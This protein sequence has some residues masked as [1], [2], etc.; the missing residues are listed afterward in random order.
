MD[1]SFDEILVPER[2]KRPSGSPGTSINKRRKRQDDVWRQSASSEPGTQV[3]DDFKPATLRRD[4]DTQRSL[5]C[6]YHKRDPRLHHRT[7][8]RLLS[9]ENMR[10]VKFHIERVHMKPPWCGCCRS[11]DICEPT[12]NKLLSVNLNRAPFSKNS[13]TEKWAL[14]YELLFGND[15]LIPSPYED[16]IMTKE[17]E[18]MFLSILTNRLSE[19]LGPTADPTLHQLPKLLEECRLEVLNT[20]IRGVITAKRIDDGSGLDQ[21]QNP[22]T[23]TLPTEPTYLNPPLLNESTFMPESDAPPPMDSGFFSANMF[24][25]KECRCHLISN[26]LPA[27][28]CPVPSNPMSMFSAYQFHPNLP[29]GIGDGSWIVGPG[30]QFDSQSSGHTTVSG[31]SLLHLQS[32]HS[33]STLDDNAQ[34]AIAPESFM[35]TSYEWIF[36][37]T[38]CQLGAPEQHREVLG[39]NASL[40]VAS[41]L[42]VDRH[43]MSAHMQSLGFRG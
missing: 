32:D 40:P 5:K 41:L 43:S 17:E 2:Y 10:D 4:E 13:R 42:G 35:N 19:T 26:P 31:H 34:I 7:S 24:V 37:G 36:G 18:D 20:G 25:P 6:P 30:G 12:R 28:I 23:W 9:Y 38:E 1:D 33:P 39:S 27:P 21:E 22:E 11:G 29:D 16:R 14:L 3:H 15:V 8:C